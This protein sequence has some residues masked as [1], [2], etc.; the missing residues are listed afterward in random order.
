MLRNVT[1]AH[2]GLAP[3]GKNTRQFCSLKFICIFELFIELSDGCALLMQGTHTRFKEPPVPFSVE[4]DASF[5]NSNLFGTFTCGAA[6]R[7]AETPVA[8]Q[9]ADR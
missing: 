6:S 2:K 5:F 7:C 3:S 1:S 8:L 4:S 9:T